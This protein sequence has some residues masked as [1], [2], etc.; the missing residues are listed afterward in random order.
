MKQVL[1]DVRLYAVKN[2]K[3]NKQVE[4]LILKGI[5]WKFYAARKAYEYSRNILEKCWPEGEK[6]I[7]KC[8]NTSYLYARFVIKGRWLKAEENIAK[9]GNSSYL[10]AKH[11]IKGRFQKFEDSCLSKAGSHNLYRYARYIIKGR[12]EKAEKY[13][14]ADLESSLCYAI[15]CL[16]GRWKSQERKIEI[17]IAKNGWVR[18]SSHKYILQYVASVMKKRWK[19]IEPIILG[20]NI[21]ISEYMKFLQGE[22]KLEFHNKIIL[23]AMR[24]D[25]FA[26]QARGSKTWIK[27]NPDFS[28]KSVV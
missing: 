24:D 26:W 3:T 18:I 4:N 10:Y 7:L 2:S 16:K 13:I 22:D 25:D 6:V 1:V 28:R 17:A 8:A 11:V 15:Y 19:A 5:P 23:D 27:L 12:W 21:S 20:D 14:K 9:D